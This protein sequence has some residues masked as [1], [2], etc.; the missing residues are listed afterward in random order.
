[1]LITVIAG[2]IAYTYVTDMCCQDSPSEVIDNDKKKKYCYTLYL[3]L[4]IF[5]LQLYNILIF[6]FAYLGVFICKDKGPQV[7][8]M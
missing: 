5:T 2:H 8:K 3:F 4:P 6:A 1:M 7:A